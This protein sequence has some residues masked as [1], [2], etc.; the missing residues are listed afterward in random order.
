MLSLHSQPSLFGGDHVHAHLFGLARAEADNRAFV[1]VDAHGFCILVFKFALLA[2]EG[3]NAIHARSELL[4][5]EES[6]QRGKARCEVTRRVGERYAVNIRGRG[7]PAGPGARLALRTGK[8][9]RYTFDGSIDR[10]AIVA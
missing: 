6:L 5:V 9:S 3:K 10:S 1:I 8:H 4:E 7:H 2:V